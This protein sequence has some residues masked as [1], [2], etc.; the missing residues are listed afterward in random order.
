MLGVVDTLHGAEAFFVSAHGG[1][2]ALV[3]RGELPGRGFGNVLSGADLIGFVLNAAF[4]FPD[5]FKI[6]LELVLV[7]GAEGFLERVGVVEN[8]V[9]DGA[10]FRFAFTTFV[11][12]SEEAI[13]SAL[14]INLA[15]KWDVR[16]FPG[17]VGAVEPG[18]VDVAVDP[19]SDG[20][21][22]KLH[23]GKLGATANCFG[24]EL[25]D[26]DSIGGDIRSRG[27]GDG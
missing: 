17:N 12:V 6:L 1:A 10:V 5:A 27:A 25:V 26:G 3:E 15:R 13:E 24:G 21:G 22:A 2:D 14:W 19:G 23:G 4:D 7:L 11:G 18:Q 20:L 16:F 8:N 9:D